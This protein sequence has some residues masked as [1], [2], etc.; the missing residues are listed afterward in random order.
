MHKV[1]FLFFSQC[2]TFSCL[3]F[4]PK[5]SPDCTVLQTKPLNSGDLPV[6]VVINSEEC[7]VWLNSCGLAR[8]QQHCYSH[9]SSSYPLCQQQW[10][11]VCEKAKQFLWTRI[12]SGTNPREGPCKGSWINRM[13][14]W[15]E[16]LW[17]FQ[18]TAVMWGLHLHLYKL[19]AKKETIGKYQ[20]I[21]CGQN[22]STF[23]RRLLEK[24]KGGGGFHFYW[25]TLTKM[26]L[27]YA[28]T[29]GFLIFCLQNSNQV[30]CCKKKK[31]P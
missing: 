6:C 12:K 4:F 11:H 21:I 30:Q 7:F 2:H 23:I 18:Q 22:E 15:L 24:S 25:T 10:E 29:S 5:Q 14:A 17:L 3:Q 19:S 20:P 27:L 28:F 16:N 8:L 13:G 26:L 1:S 9:N 31:K